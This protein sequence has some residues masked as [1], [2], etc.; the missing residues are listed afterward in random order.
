MCNIFIPNKNYHNHPVTLLPPWTSEPFEL[1]AAT[2]FRKSPT[3]E[4]TQS[5]ARHASV[6]RTPPGL[7][8]YSRPH[9]HT[10][11]R[12]SGRGHR[13]TPRRLS[14]RPRIVAACR[15][16]GSF[17]SE[18]LR[19]RLWSARRRWRSRSRRGRGCL[20]TCRSG[21]FCSSTG[22]GWWLDDSSPPGCP[23]CDGT[24]GRLAPECGAWLLL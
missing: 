18:P 3:A 15:T 5:S 22:N 6:G 17:G 19:R 8:L 9:T 7:P 11:M 13:R 23:E 2:I 4:Q 14:R 16:W 1:T 24:T 10:R 20:R 12:C 21:R